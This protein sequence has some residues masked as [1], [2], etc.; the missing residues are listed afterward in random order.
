[1][2]HL[3]RPRVSLAHWFSSFNFIDMFIQIGGAIGD[4]EHI[5]CICASRVSNVRSAQVISCFITA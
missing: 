4:E 2:A 5:I 1:M 3:G